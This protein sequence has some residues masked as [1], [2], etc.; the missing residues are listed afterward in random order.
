MISLDANVLVRLLTNDEPKQVRLAR[1][2]LDL[3]LAEGKTVWVSVIVLCE[4]V[5]V[6]QGLY[7][8][9]KKQVI[10]AIDALLKFSGIEVQSPRL[11]KKTL[12]VLAGN[13]VDFAD[14]LLGLVSLDA[15]ADYLLRAPS[16]AAPI[17]SAVAKPMLQVSARP[18]TTTSRAVEAS[19]V[20]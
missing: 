17:I 5:W 20:M 7:K 8:Y 11:V 3:A 10:T 16:T 12:D 18:V 2:A 14:I 4:L 13:S 15:G 19:G 6:L 1:K 9:D